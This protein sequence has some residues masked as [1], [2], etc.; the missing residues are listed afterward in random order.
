MLRARRVL[1]LVGVVAPWAALCACCR[2]IPSQIW[3]ELSR[4]KFK[5]CCPG[6]APGVRNLYEY[7]IHYQ[8][9][10]SPF[11]CCDECFDGGQSS[12]RSEERRVGRECMVAGARGC[13]RDVIS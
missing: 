9:S 7:P 3:V 1:C 11:G 2:N 6:G 13:E 5:C 8:I 4:L 10:R 12:D